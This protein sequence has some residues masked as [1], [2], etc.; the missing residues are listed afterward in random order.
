ME[1]SEVSRWLSSISC[2]LDFTHLAN[3]FEERGFTTKLSLKYVESS[4]LDVFFPSPRKLSYAQKKILLTEIQKLPAKSAVQAQ[5][6]SAT[7]SIMLDADQLPEKYVNV[8]VVNVRETKQT[9][10]NLVETPASSGSFQTLWLPAKCSVQAQDTSVTTSIL[11]DAD[12]LP[13]KYVNVD[14]N[15]EILNVWETNQTTATPASSGSFQ[16]L[17]DDKSSQMPTGF[18]ANKEESITGDVQFLQSQI[19]SAKEQYT[20]LEQQADKYDQ[21]ATKRAKVCSNCHLPGHNKGK[22]NNQICY[23]IE[24]CNLR[25]KHPEMKTAMTELQRLIKSL[26]KKAEK[27]RNEF[28]AFKAA[29]EKACN[30]FFAIMRPRLKKQNAMKYAG[31]DRILLDR[32]L[33][34]LKKALNN[35]VPVDESDDW[36]LPMIIE[37][38]KM[39]MVTFQESMS[40]MFMK[41]S[42]SNMYRRLDFL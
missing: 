22:C 42:S 28:L 10:A 34:T 29:R 25:S 1:G 18:L 27:S 3:D 16:T 36:R 15:V 5:D 33:M 37:Q 35:K 30:S 13:E 31:T 12:Q 14:S 40:D 9:T 24:N 8:E 6:T 17:G 38:F 2:G 11:L 39:N 23:G 19:M 32:D 26:E 4:D 41:P 7:T 21:I 20:R